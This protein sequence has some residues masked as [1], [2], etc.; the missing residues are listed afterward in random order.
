MNPERLGCAGSRYPVNKGKRSLRDIAAE[1][2][3]ARPPQRARQAL[4]PDRDLA[5][6]GVVTGAASRFAS[7]YR[8]ASENKKARDCSRAAAAFSGLVG[9][10]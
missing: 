4:R 5:D 6:A 3:G 2:G 9:Q 7:A 1:L 8:A 10:K